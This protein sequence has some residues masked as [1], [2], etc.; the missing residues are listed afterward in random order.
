MADETLK[1]G[2]LVYFVAGG[3]RMLIVAKYPVCNLLDCEWFTNE[4]EYRKA[5]FKGDR[6]TTRNPAMSHVA[7]VRG[8]PVN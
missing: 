6:L 3:P 5:T 1:P 4:G 7:P 8:V 2:D